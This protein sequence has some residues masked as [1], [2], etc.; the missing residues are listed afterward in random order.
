MGDGVLRRK[1]TKARSAKHKG[2]TAK[3]VGVIE[4]SCQMIA[5]KTRGGRFCGPG[6]DD[7]RWRVASAEGLSRAS[8]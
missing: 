1:G 4:R 6:S 7:K 5:A 8:S 2:R 3:Q